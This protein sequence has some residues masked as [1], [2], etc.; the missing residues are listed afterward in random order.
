MNGFSA[1]SQGGM[2]GQGGARHPDRCST[3]PAMPASPRPTS[4]EASDSL[5]LL[6]CQLTI[7]MPVSWKN[8]LHQIGI[9]WDRSAAST[10]I[11]RVCNRLH[12]APLHVVPTPEWHRWQQL[13][14]ARLQLMKALGAT[15]TCALGHATALGEMKQVLM[16]VFH[17][18]QEEVDDPPVL[19]SKLAALQQRM[20]CHKAPPSHKG[21][22]C[23][24]TSGPDEELVLPVGTRVSTLVTLAALPGCN[25]E[26][27]RVFGTI[28]NAR[29][30][31]PTG[32]HTYPVLMQHKTSGQ[33]IVVKLHES[34]LRLEILDVSDTIPHGWSQ[35]P[36]KELFTMPLSCTN[37]HSIGLI[38]LPILMGDDGLLLSDSESGEIRWAAQPHA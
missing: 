23:T 37:N 20:E 6:R 35:Q 22:R 15:Q 4:R 25:A 19:A 38:G 12:P 32:G 26:V 11:Q 27:D 30:E 2:G 10:L 33:L 9:P 3:P 24:T 13:D 21:S 17:L 14:T 34:D 5:S 18:Q 36:P 16:K 31:C 29:E 28:V 8:V 1:D 7:H